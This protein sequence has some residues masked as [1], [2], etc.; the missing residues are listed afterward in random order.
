MAN[1]PF[2]GWCELWRDDAMQVNAQ[3]ES[4]FGTPPGYVDP[5]AY[6]GKIASETLSYASRED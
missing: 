4:E 6:R 5:T 3:Q 2:G 1:T